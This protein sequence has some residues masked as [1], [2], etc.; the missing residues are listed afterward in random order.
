MA[1]YNVLSLTGDA[2]SKAFA[3]ACF[4][5]YV[6][7]SDYEEPSMGTL[8]LMPAQAAESSAALPPP[9]EAHFRPVFLMLLDSMNGVHFGSEQL[10]SDWNIFDPQMDFHYS[11]EYG[12]AQE[13]GKYLHGR[14]IAS[15]V[16]NEFFGE[17]NHDYAKPLFG[18]VH[19]LVSRQ[20]TP[21]VASSLSV[22]YIYWRIEK[23]LQQHSALTIQLNRWQTEFQ[24]ALLQILSHF[25]QSVSEVNQQ[26][27][28]T[29][30]LHK[31]C[32][33]IRHRLKDASLNFRTWTVHC[34]SFATF[35]SAPRIWCFLTLLRLRHDEDFSRSLWDKGFRHVTCD[36]DPPQEEEGSVLEWRQAVRAQGV[37]AGEAAASA[38]T[39]ANPFAI[40]NTYTEDETLVAKLLA[41]E[42]RQVHDEF[43]CATGEHVPSLPIFSKRESKTSLRMPLIFRGFSFIFKEP[44]HGNATFLDML[45]TSCRQS[46]AEAMELL[47][48]ESYD[49]IIK[50]RYRSD[51]TP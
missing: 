13:I 9:Q 42:G 39:A 33:E 41:G 24:G 32:K 21:A 4:S 37:V 2:A 18:Y 46:D 51:L 26:Y 23:E 43:R 47:G 15:P 49:L 31:M 14:N 28:L 30:F 40:S 48:K 27:A 44:D 10:A 16:I 36:L 17:V 38:G 3:D 1:S 20:L 22:I 8:H 5:D 45:Q 19:Q 50:G 6:S 29:D 35:S 7:F 34:G 25:A 12:L 11:G